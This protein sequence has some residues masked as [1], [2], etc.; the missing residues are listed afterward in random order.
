[1]SY[2]LTHNK[3]LVLASSIATIFT[4]NNNI[5]FNMRIE[6]IENVEN[7]SKPYQSSL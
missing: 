6:K 3:S 1:M 4:I 5:Q 7:I 2:S